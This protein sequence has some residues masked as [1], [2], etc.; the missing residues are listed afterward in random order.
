[1]CK[2]GGGEVGGRRGGHTTRRCPSPVENR[3]VGPD[4]PARAQPLPCHGAP[5]TRHGPAEWS[6][7]CSILSLQRR[8]NAA[9][10]LRFNAPLAVV[11]YALAP[12]H[13]STHGCGMCG[14]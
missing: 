14:Q 13:I 7:E 9:S 5:S 12:A 1:M 11:N 10:R 6:A 2:R 4:P 3:L 8:R